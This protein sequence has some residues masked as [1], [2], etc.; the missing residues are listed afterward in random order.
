MGRK[1]LEGEILARQAFQLSTVGMYYESRELLH[2]I[3]ASVLTKEGRLEYYNAR[4]H[5]YHE[6]SYYTNVDWIKKK[7]KALEW[8]LIDSLQFV[9]GKNDAVYYKWKG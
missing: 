7:Y 6:L 9:T 3:D 5:L 2:L 8:R 4:I 1:D